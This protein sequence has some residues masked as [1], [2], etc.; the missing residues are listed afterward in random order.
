VAVGLLGTPWLLN[1]YALSSIALAIAASATLYLAIRLRGGWR[2]HYLILGAS[3]YLIYGL[4][5]YF[6]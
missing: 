2:P 3:F 4:I 5:I 1:F 6:I